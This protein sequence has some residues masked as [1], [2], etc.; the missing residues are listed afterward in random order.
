MG[1][2]KDVLAVSCAMCGWQSAA[3]PGIQTCHHWLRLA[4][5]PSSSISRCAFPQPQQT[6]QHRRPACSSP[7]GLHYPEG[8]P[9]WPEEELERV[10]REHKVDRCLLSYSDLPHSKVMLLAAR[11]LAGKCGCS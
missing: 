6:P 7:A 5:C 9:I 4:H 3:P 8:L 1:F 11:C 10:I 2:A